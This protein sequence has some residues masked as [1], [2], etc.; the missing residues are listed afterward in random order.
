MDASEE[1]R[2]HAAETRQ[3][4]KRTASQV[5]EP[6]ATKK[7]PSELSVLEKLKACTHAVALPDGWKSPEVE[8]DQ[9]VHGTSSCPG[10]PSSLLISFDTTIARQGG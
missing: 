2:R 4:L 10:L 3:A 7:G 9:A 8:L 6:V 1:A 5:A